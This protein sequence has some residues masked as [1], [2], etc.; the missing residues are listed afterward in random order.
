ME[1]RRKGKLYIVDFA[2]Q[3]PVYI[4]CVYMKAEEERAKRAYEL[5]QNRRYPSYQEAIHLVE[6]GNTSKLPELMA[7]DM[8]RV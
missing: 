7:E 2:E 1:F 8:H 4:T 6:D 5:V 3:R